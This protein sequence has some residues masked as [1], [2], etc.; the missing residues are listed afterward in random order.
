[1][2]HKGRAYPFRAPISSDAGQFP[3]DFDAPA[4]GIA[5]ASSK[6]MAAAD[7]SPTGVRTLLIEHVARL[8][9]VS[10]RTVYNRIREG[11]LETIR[12]RGGSQRV[13][14]RS[15]EDIRREGE[16]KRSARVPAAAA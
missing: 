2:L 4:P 6:R 15:L 12:T 7:S 11:R 9:G 16:R 10:R 13:V 8:M 1:M 3:K 14:I 5:C